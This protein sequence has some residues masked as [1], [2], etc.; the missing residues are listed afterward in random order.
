MHFFPANPCRCS[1][2]KPKLHKG[3]IFP[4]VNVHIHTPLHPLCSDETEPAM[5][6]TNCLIKEKKTN[7]HY[8]FDDALP[9]LRMLLKVQHIKIHTLET[10]VN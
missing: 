6:L 5:P 9:K 8:H 3:I 2:Q 1:R 4:S 10:K 7:K